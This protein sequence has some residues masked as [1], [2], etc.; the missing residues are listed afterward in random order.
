MGTLISLVLFA[1]SGI[2]LAFAHQHEVQITNPGDRICIRS[3]GLP[4][5][6]TGTFPNRGNPHRL[7]AQDT[8]VCVSAKP[9]RNAQPMVHRGS[10]GVA[11]ETARGV[12]IH[13][14]RDMGSSGRHVTATEQTTR[15]YPR[16]RIRRALS[17]CQSRLASTARL[18]GAFLP[19]ARPI[20]S[21]ARPTSLK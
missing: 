2:T 18:S 6:A 9:V 1:A 21:L 4:D 12:A 3:N 15:R 5:H 19:L 13:R 17:R 14:A 10:V 8:R 7:R 11:R 16:S 20:S